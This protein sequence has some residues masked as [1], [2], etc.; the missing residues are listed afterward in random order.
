MIIY[1]DSRVNKSILFYIP[2]GRALIKPKLQHTINA[3]EDF[4]FRFKIRTILSNILQLDCLKT[5]LTVEFDCSNAALLI[6]HSVYIPFETDETRIS[7][8]SLTFCINSVFIEYNRK[9]VEF[10]WDV[11]VIAID[12]AFPCTQFSWIIVIFKCE[13]N[14]YH[15]FVQISLFQA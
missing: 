4:I 15:R 2:N 3:M 12:F 9:N 7:A 10:A 14:L 11:S 5:T 13:S 6:S 1:I 8:R